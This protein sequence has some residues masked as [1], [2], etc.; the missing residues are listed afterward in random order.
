M[1]PGDAPDLDPSAETAL[2]P[3]LLEV[4]TTAIIKNPNNPRR[5][6]NDERLD[7]LRTSILEVGILV[8]LIAF[9]DPT[10]PSQYILMDGERRWNCAWELALESV[11]VSLIRPPNPLENLLRMFNI[12]A[13]RD[14][15]PLI[16]VALS[17]QEIIA[18]SGEDR[19]TRLA[20]MTG[21]GRGTVRRA[22]R[23]LSL[24]ENEL[25]LIQSEAHLDRSQQVCLAT[26]L[27]LSK[28]LLCDFFE[29]CGR[30]SF[31]ILNQTL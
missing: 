11:P 30:G 21:L 8:P 27:L 7:L 1:S 28:G 5:Y 18:I 20:E 19:E 16:S 3:T 23:L 12:H 13:V 24:P 9:Q 14:D 31:R 22:K 26:G 17:L 6:F 2:E 10:D 25:D 4:P 29:D 15:W